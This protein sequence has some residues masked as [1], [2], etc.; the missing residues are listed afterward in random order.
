MC[1]L[2]DLQ[3]IVCPAGGALRNVQSHL[4]RSMML[5]QH[6]PHNSLFSESCK[7]LAQ[8]KLDMSEDPW[9]IV[10]LLGE[11]AAISLRHQFLSH[12]HKQIR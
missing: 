4:A 8:I 7:V 9:E 2:F 5:N 3:L 10:A 6:F 12:F 11:S 1:G